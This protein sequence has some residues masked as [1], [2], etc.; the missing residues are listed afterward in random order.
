LQRK[1]AG[2]PFVLVGS[3][4]LERDGDGNVVQYLP[5]SRYANRDNLQLNPYGHGPFCRFRIARGREWQQSGVYVLTRGASPI[6]VG[7]TVDLERRWG[8]NGF[9]GI[10]PRNCFQ[11]GQPTNCRLN[12]LILTGSKSGSQF[13][14]WFYPIDGDKH[15]RLDVERLLVARLNPSW[16]R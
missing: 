15:A 16:N 6:Y 2:L 14:L 7:E 4:Q 10:S 11:R 9:G 1:F 12:N 13:D 3:I 5:Q 8:S